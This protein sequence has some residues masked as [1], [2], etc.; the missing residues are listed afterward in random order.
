MFQI[1]TWKVRDTIKK[2]PYVSD[3]KINRKIN[4]TVEI[5][6]TE[7]I[8]KYLVK[9]GKN[10]IYIDVQ[11]YILET[12]SKNLEL[13]ILKGLKTEVNSMIPGSRLVKE[14]LL[15]LDTVAQIMESA[16]ASRFESLITKIDITDEKAYKLVLEKGKK[17]AYLGD[18][19]KIPQKM[20]W[21]AKILE[22]EKGIKGEI[23]V[24]NIEKS[25]VFFRES[26]I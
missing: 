6:I 26:L 4:G 24:T 22:E 25:K 1:N 5:N 11:G 15:K 14:D 3:V 9:I 19:A 12:T 20:V 7:R 8:P 21:I 18:G 17:V 10:Y 23:F 13:P 16:K 2:N